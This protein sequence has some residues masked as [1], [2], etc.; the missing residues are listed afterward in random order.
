MSERLVW[1]YG[2][3]ELAIV[4]TSKASEG[5]DILSQV[6]GPKVGAIEA[7]THTARRERAQLGN[8]SLLLDRLFP[9]ASWACGAR[10]AFL[11]GLRLAKC[12]SAQPAEPA[13]ACH[14]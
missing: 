5:V 3:F 11:R 1:G 9:D 14:G 13:C 4:N 10:L 8:G 6:K 2:Y 12:T 7:F